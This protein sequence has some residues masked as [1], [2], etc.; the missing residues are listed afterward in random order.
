MKGIMEDIRSSY[1]DIKNYGENRHYREQQKLW[2]MVRKER[3]LRYAG[4]N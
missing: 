3:H 2:R 4:H 1:E